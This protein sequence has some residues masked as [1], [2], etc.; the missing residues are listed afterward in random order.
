M[1][2][3]RRRYKRFAIAILV[4]LGGFFSVPPYTFHATYYF[5]S[6]NDKLNQMDKD[7]SSSNNENWPSEYNLAPIIKNE[8]GARIYYIGSEHRF[9][10]RYDIAYIKGANPNEVCSPLSIYSSKRIKCDIPLSS[11]WVLNFEVMESNI[12]VNTDFKSE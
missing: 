5:F 6:N 1:S 12:T 11:G 7:F 10:N 9:G 2:K 4:L 8:S 3:I